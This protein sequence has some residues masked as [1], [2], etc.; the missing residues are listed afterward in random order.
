MIMNIPNV[1]SIE[2]EAMSPCELSV[3]M[4]KIHSNELLR[5]KSGPNRVLTE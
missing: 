5:V 4:I 1:C 2:C 3:L